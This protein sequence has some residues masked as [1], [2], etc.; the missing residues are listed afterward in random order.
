MASRNDV[1]RH[2]NST[3]ALVP[4][5]RQVQAIVARVVLRVDTALAAL[6]EVLD[7]TGVCR[8]PR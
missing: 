8:P 5:T 2:A 7:A 3:G 6:L 4:E 1:A